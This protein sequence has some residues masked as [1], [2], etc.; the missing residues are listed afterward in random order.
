MLVGIRFVI[1][2]EQNKCIFFKF[3]DRELLVGYF[4]RNI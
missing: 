4:L 1:L 2:I 3:S